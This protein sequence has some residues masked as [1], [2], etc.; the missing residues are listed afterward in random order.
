MGEVS[1][2]GKRLR[3]FRKRAKLTQVELADLAGINRTVI[4]HAERGFRHHMLAENLS[5][6]A[7]ALNVSMDQLYG[8][9]LLEESEKETEALAATA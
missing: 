9:D 5:K 7:R 3:M 1:R 8:H 2:L 4:S 6:L